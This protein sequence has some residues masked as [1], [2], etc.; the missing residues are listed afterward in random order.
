MYSSLSEKQDQLLFSTTRFMSSLVV[1]R[2]LHSFLLSSVSVE[3]HQEVHHYSTAFSLR[4]WCNH[5]LSNVNHSSSNA[6]K[7]GAQMCSNDRFRKNWTVTLAF[8]TTNFLFQTSPLS[9]TVF[10]P[11]PIELYQEMDN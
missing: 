3:L 5:E 10:S 9:F 8:S 1:F 7:G 11:V 2:C 4:G 6:G